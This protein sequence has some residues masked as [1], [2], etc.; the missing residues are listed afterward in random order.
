MVKVSKKKMVAVKTMD[1]EGKMVGTPVTPASKMIQ[2]TPSTTPGGGT[3]VREEDSSN[4]YGSAIKQER[5]SIV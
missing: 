2:R 1:L 5:T 4:S 3:R